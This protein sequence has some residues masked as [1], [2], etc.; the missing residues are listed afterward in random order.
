MPYQPYEGHPVLAAIKFE[1]NKSISSGDLL[2]H[3]AT[4][5][6]SGFFSKT[7]RYY[8]A[9][10]F[11][12]DVRRVVRWYNQKGFYEARVLDVEEQKDDKGR[13]TLVVKID[14]GRRAIVRQQQYEGIEDLSGDERSDIDDALPIHPG[15]AFDEDVYEKAKDVLLDQLR[16]H[17]FARA[18]VRG[19][20]EVAPAE[21][22]AQIV[23][24]VE[25]GERF[26]FGDVTVSGNQ[27]VA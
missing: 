24:E 21:G 5:P 14:E 10:L 15:D 8:D 7:A 4:A 9:D 3:I 6:S 26:K 25:P 20:V 17:G 13:V 27:R 12:I 1:G 18:R 2:G 23:F 22:S 16:E 19:R 11:A